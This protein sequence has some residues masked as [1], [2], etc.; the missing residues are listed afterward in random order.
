MRKSFIITAIFVFTQLLTF[1]IS[2]QQPLS[3]SWQLKKIVSDG[4]EIPLAGEGK[5]PDLHFEKDTQSFYGTG[6]CNRFRGSYTIEN[7]KFNA[8][9]VMATKMACMASEL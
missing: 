9:P 6:G 3:G 8:G 1:S 4:S 5:T 7:G 2:A